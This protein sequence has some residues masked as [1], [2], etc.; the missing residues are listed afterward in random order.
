MYEI[1]WNSDAKAELK[2]IFRQSED[3]DGLITTLALL[4]KE[5]RTV[6]L[7]AGFGRE[8]SVHRMHYQRPLF[9]EYEV[10]EDDKRVIVLSVLEYHGN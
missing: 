5:L 7:L 4:Q 10:I 1:I 6:P 8:S 9:I 2:L 3:P